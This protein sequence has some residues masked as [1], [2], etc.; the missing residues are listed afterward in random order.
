MQCL[1]GEETFDTCRPYE[2]HLYAWG[3]PH[4]IRPIAVNGREFQVT[5]NLE[6]ALRSL[7]RVDD[8]LRV[9]WIDALCINQQ[10]N[11]EK[12]NQ[13]AHMD[14]VYKKATNV[15]IWL[16]KE[17]ADTGSTLQFLDHFQQG[18]KEIPNF[19]DVILSTSHSLL[20]NSAANVQE[21]HKLLRIPMVTL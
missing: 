13:V 12:K 1:R 18:L 14:V 11:E 7:R 10:H 4:A 8:R 19:M 2:A 15:L 9:L 20:R 6:N 21:H 3:D 16:G 5:K 17:T